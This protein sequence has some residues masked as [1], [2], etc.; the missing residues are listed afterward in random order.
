M[1][2]FLHI[3]GNNYDY[4]VGYYGYFFSEVIAVHLYEYVGRNNALNEFVE[5]VLMPGN[6][7]PGLI[8]V[9]EFCGHWDA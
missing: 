6:K 2:T 7:K 8:L 4:T 9:E 3:F 5:K 1:H